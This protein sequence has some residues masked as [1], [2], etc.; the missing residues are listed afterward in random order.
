MGNPKSSWKQEDI[1]ADWKSHARTRPLYRISFVGK[2][3]QYDKYMEL[4]DTCSKLIIM[5]RADARW[6]A[7]AKLAEWM[8]SPGGFTRPHLPYFVSLEEDEQELFASAL[9]KYHPT[10]YHKL[11]AYGE[12]I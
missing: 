5:L 11:R 3:E 7:A 2:S 4:R 6:Q 8:R 12:W 10:M 9:L 1:R